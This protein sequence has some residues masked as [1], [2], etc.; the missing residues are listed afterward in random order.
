M[1]IVLFFC[2]FGDFNNNNN[3][4]RVISLFL[5]I[6]R[7]KLMLNIGLIIIIVAKFGDNFTILSSES[8]I[9]LRI[10]L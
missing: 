4:N 6:S 3:A 2:L 8:F 5:T 7:V 9:L 1:N 10:S